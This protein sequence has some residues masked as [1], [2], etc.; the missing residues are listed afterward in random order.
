MTSDA[1]RV[2]RARVAIYGPAA[3][4]AFGVLLLVAGAVGFTRVQFHD[5]TTHAGSGTPA[6]AAPDGRVGARVGA[7][8]V[9]GPSSPA[10]Q[11]APPGAPGQASISAPTQGRFLLV[12]A[13]AQLYAIGDLSNP[14][15]G[16][17]GS[18]GTPGRRIIGAAVA[19]TGGAWLATADGHVYASNAPDLGGVTLPRGAGAIVGIASAVGGHGF[20]M[21]GSDGRV[22]AVGAPTR[23]SLATAKSAARVV[24]I[25]TSAHDGYWIA[26]SDG[27]VARFGAAPALGGTRLATGA[28][29]IVGMSATL[30]GTGYWLATTDGHV[31]AYGAPFR[32]DLATQ[33]IHDKVV[34]IAP[35][36]MDGYWLTNA[37]GRVYP[38]GAPTFDTPPATG[39]GA[40]IVAM[41]PY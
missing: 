24:G 3:T 20:R 13:D 30:D 28:A 7:N 18:A 1:I 37:D 32:G 16:V 6:T 33:H 11:P 8:P 27:T 26:R 2:R 15:A 25:A 22:Y 12:G 29:R 39:S 40:A 5:A 36:A 21:V 35:S 19:A 31:H 23:G 4:G 17:S 10:A 41:I 14:R 34:A 9:P 38:F